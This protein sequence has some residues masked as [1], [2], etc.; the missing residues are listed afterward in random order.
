MTQLVQKGAF[1]TVKQEVL[2]TVGG[3][4]NIVHGGGYGPST[5]SAASKIIFVIGKKTQ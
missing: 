2:D 1:Q 5:V 3:G 4:G